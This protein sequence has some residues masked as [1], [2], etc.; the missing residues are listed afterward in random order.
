LCGGD[1]AALLCG[2][3]VAALLRGADVAALLCGGDVAA[4]LCGGMLLRCRAVISA[5]HT[6]HTQQPFTPPPIYN[7]LE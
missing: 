2:G 4:L 6:R 1:V 5:P 7:N 3:D